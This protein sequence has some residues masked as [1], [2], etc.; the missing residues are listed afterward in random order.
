MKKHNIFIDFDGT[1]CFDCFWR[2]APKNISAP[3]VK[4]LFQDN[5]CLVENW[6]RGKFSSEEIVAEISKNTGFDYGLIWDIF[7][8]DC[9]N[10]YV[11]P[12]ILQA[13]TKCNKNNNTILITDN[14]DCFNRFTSPRLQFEK[15]F[16][17]IFNSSDFGVL[18]DDLPT[19]GLFKKILDLY[20][21]EIEK[22]VLI[23]DS[24]KN[25]EI[26]TQLGG[27]SFLIKNVQTVL[28][29]LKMLE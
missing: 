1:I 10:M 17:Y 18:K 21:F 27:T 4:F 7:V 3:I 9:Q 28:P 15:Y 23:D 16:S 22:S 29:I 8:K 6:M 26:F 12:E 24:D 20:D 13:V 11:N 19:K 5:V 14:M 25:C 2:S